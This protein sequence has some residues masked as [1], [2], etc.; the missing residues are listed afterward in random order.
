MNV[1]KGSYVK[2]VVQNN[3]VITG[4]YQAD[5]QCLPRPPPIELAGRRTRK[6]AWDFYKSIFKD[7]RP[8]TD[9]LLKNCYETD[10]SLTKLPVFIP[11]TLKDETTAAA[12]KEALRPHYRKIREVYKYYSAIAPQGRIM[13]VGAGV[14]TEMVR[15][16]PGLIDGKTLNMTDLDICIIACN[17]GV[18]KNP[19]NPLQAIVRHQ[20]LEVLVRLS[21]DKYLKSGSASTLTSAVDMLMT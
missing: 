12:V 3:S 15:D 10:W 21:I 19:L 11:K 14:L 1:P 17:G 18:K 2:N 20:M 9:A 6:V 13:C 8:D 5:L 16:C 7:Y 4:T